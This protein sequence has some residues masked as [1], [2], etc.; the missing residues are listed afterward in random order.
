MAPTEQA[1]QA[2]STLQPS[3]DV[4]LE[5][6]LTA[7]SPT[8]EIGPVVEQ[9]RAALPSWS[10]HPSTDD[11]GNLVATVGQG[12]VQVALVGHI[13]TV[14]GQVPVR[15]D[16]DRLFGRGAVDAKG[17][18]AAFCAAAVAAVSVEPQL[19]VHLI[20]CKDEEGPSHG[21]R[22]AAPHYHPHYAIVGEP[23]G[24]AAVTLGYKGTIKLTYTRR[25][26]SAHSSNGEASNALDDTLTFW[27]R[28]LAFHSE[29]TVPD[30]A[31][32]SLQMRPLS[33]QSVDDGMGMEATLRVDFRIPPG[34]DV[35]KLQTFVARYGLG[36][37]VRWE[38]WEEP[39]VVEKNTPLV[40]AFLAAIR[41][42][43]GTPTF[44]KKTGTADLNILSP[45]WAVPM[46]AYGPGDSHL[47]H[48]PTEH[49]TIPELTMGARVLTRVLLQLAQRESGQGRARP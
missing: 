41:A 4:L 19:Q 34:F 14:R 5:G 42:E 38:G 13:D 32:T 22:F 3:L 27:N 9:L 12:P 43:G 33:L 8:G 24:S 20:G 44:K 15:R 18:F 6:M 16:G 36:G 11:I 2:L 28:L 17:P 10:I 23:S 49:T 29:H 40:R 30:S 39:V 1:L 7:Y 31:F 46:V 47:D 35:L 48:T 26:D 25:T 21:A 45:R 37:E